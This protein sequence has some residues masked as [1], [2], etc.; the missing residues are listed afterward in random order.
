MPVFCHFHG[1]CFKS[2]AFMSKFDAYIMSLSCLLCNERA[3]HATHPGSLSEG[4]IPES[5]AT[6]TPPPQFGQCTL[7]RHSAAAC[8]LPHEANGIGEEVGR[9][10]GPGRFLNRCPSARRS[11][12][13]DPGLP[14]RRPKRSLTRAPRGRLDRTQQQSRCTPRTPPRRVP[15]ISA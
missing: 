13:T 3:C 8:H 10:P 1:S 6:G 2:L 11:E 15:A 7:P 5:I 14:V 12:A 9:E 4:G